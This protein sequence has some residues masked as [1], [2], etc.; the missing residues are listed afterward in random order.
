MTITA[1]QIQISTLPDG[2]A[3]TADEIAARYLPK[4]RPVF[5]VT[6]A[7]GMLL[8]MFELLQAAYSPRKYFR[9][10]NHHSNCPLGCDCCRPCHL[11]TAQYSH[12]PHRSPYN[13]V[14]LAA[15]VIP[16]TG[17]FV[18]LFAKPE[19]Q[20]SGEQEIKKEGPE[21]FWFMGLGIFFL[22]LNM[23]KWFQEQS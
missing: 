13:Y 7:I 5:M 22:Y 19:T 4:W 18:F 10:D 21:Q 1:K 9:Y 8:I 3:P 12:S 23:V 15:F 17:C 6:I 16:L 14:D 2:D 20:I 11:L